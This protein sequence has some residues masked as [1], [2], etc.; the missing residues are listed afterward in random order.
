[1]QFVRGNLLVCKG[2][3][4]PVDP[5]SNA[6]PTSVTAT[7]NYVNV[8]GSRSEDTVA[9]ALSIDG[10]TWYGTWDSS[11][12]AAGSVDWKVQATS[13]LKAAAQGTFVVLANLANH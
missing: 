1:M 10:V 12:A 13:G 4:I 8:S 5:L 11:N 9:M 2:Q 3:F 6:V 7:L